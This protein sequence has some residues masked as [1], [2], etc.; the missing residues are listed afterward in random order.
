MPAVSDYAPGTA[1]ELMDT[2]YS[3]ASLY[4]LEDDPAFKK[5]IGFKDHGWSTVE[6]YWYESDK[7]ARCLMANRRFGD[8]AYFVSLNIELVLSKKQ[9]AAVWG[10]I[11]RNFRRRGLVGFWVREGSTNG[12]VN[13][14]VIV[15]NECDVNAIIRASVEPVLKPWKTG[16]RHPFHFQAEPWEDRNS[17]L[18][19]RYVVKAKTAKYMDGVLV[20]KDRWAS[21]RTFFK[22]GLRIVKCREI[23][24]F[25]GKSKAQL[26]N[27][28]KDKERR[29][30]D[31]LKIP[32]AEAHAAE[33]Y[34]LTQGFFSWNHVRRAVGYFSEECEAEGEFEKYTSPQ[35][36]EAVVVAVIVPPLER[37]TAAPKLAGVVRH[38]IGVVWRFFRRP[39]EP[40]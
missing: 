17:Y 7:V 16:N 25:W 37:I 21:K 5:R 18:T 1:G 39:K 10:K 13:Y 14:H 27:E 26:W 3:T 28:I 32:G 31:G 22:T 35:E 23:G 36:A 24:K 9:V 33:L 40:P 12:H 11:T 15:K 29:I 8:Y 19:C 20:S 6:G 30:S 38:F 2:V 4:L 34:D